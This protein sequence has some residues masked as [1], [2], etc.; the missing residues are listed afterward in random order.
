VGNCPSDASIL[1][2]GYHCRSGDRTKKDSEQ[3]MKR[4]RGSTSTS[5][6]YACRASLTAPLDPATLRVVQ[7]HSNKEKLIMA[8]KEKVNKSQA[9][10]DYI[11]ANRKATNTEVAEALAKKGI[12]LTA[13]YVATL[14]SQAKSK[15]RARKAAAAQPVA[16]ARKVE[17]APALAVASETPAKS[18]NAITL[19]QIKMV[20]QMVK[21]IGGFGRL[22]EM[23]GVIKEVG[24]LKKFKDL[25]D[26]MAVSETGG[27]SS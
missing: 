19:E 20:G 26:A 16:E 22:H 27:T 23:L 15:R 9:V 1:A 7:P 6:R 12:K 17:A 5:P 3:L 14:K 25:L 2:I 8:K 13:N 4:L 10:R 11:R 24:G 21:T 18:T